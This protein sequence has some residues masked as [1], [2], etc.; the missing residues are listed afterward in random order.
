MKITLFTSG[1]TKEPKKITHNNMLEHIKRSVKELDL[2][3]FDKVLDVFP[4]NVIAH[5][6]VT[7]QPAIYAGA[8]LITTKFDP[9]EYLKLFNEFKTNR[10]SINS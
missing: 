6:T 8:H 10:Y 3:P 7:A 5:Y 4:A 9:F 2:K 1:S